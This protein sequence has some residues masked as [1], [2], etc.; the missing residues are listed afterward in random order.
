MYTPRDFPICKKSLKPT[1]QVVGQNK[2]EKKNSTPSSKWKMKR[3]KNVSNKKYE[4]T[5]TPTGIV[6]LRS[7][8]HNSSIW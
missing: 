4:L 1:L 3:K 2:K 6:Q 7:G 5:D 8:D